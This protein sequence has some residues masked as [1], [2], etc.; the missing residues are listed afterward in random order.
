MLPDR[1]KS[2]GP[3]DAGV[4]IVAYAAPPSRRITG[5]FARVSTL[6][7]VVGLPKSPFATG[8]GGLLRGSARSPSIDSKSAVSSPA[9]YAPAPRRT[10]TSNDQPESRML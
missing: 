7:T 2:F 4:P 8:N 1:Q 10:S 5:T 3:V 9:M 6:L